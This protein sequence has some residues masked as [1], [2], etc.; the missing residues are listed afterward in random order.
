MTAM[1]VAAREGPS[2]IRTIL[3]VPG[4]RIDRVTA[5]PA[6]GSD[7]VWIDLEEPRTPFT[8]DQRVAARAEVGAFLP[9]GR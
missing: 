3:N 4:D 6:A 8:E 5:A 1:A 2:R 7:A 9:G